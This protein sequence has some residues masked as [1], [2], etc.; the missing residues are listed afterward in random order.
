MP[1]SCGGN[2]FDPQAA[3]NIFQTLTKV[4]VREKSKPVGYLS[5]ATESSADGRLQRLAVV[6]I[7]KLTKLSIKHRFAATIQVAGDHRYSRSHCLKENKPETL[8]PPRHD[9][10]IGETIVVSLFRFRHTPRE[11][12]TAAEPERRRLMLQALFVVAVSGD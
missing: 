4:L 12:H 5:R 11:Y 7:S 6:R 2:T 10:N 3:H 1:F 8:L 9:K